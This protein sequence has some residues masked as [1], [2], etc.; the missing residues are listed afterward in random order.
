MDLY[1]IFIF[2][3]D[4]L[5]QLKWYLKGHDLSICCYNYVLNVHINRLISCRH[6]SLEGYFQ[7]KIQYKYSCFYILAFGLDQFGSV[8]ISLAISQYTLHLVD[9]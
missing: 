6:I 7:R 2:C 1:Q 3:I 4:K 5:Q 9:S 8:V